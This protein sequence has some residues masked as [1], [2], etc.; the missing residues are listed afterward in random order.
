MSNNIEDKVNAVL[1]GT[2]PLFNNESQAEAIL[3]VLEIR[4]MGERLSAL[5][6]AMK[7]IN[8]EHESIDVWDIEDTA[9]EAARAAV[10]DELNDHQILEAEEALKMY[11]EIKRMHQ[12]IMDRQQALGI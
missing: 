11:N 6:D 5:E 8:T 2:I 10:V 12:E 1:D 4:E 9:A 3:R 7:N